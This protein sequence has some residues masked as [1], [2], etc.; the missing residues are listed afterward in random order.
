MRERISRSIF[1]WGERAE[2]PGP[3]TQS[4][5]RLSV[6][7]QSTDRSPRSTVQILGHW[8]SFSA[9]P[10][11]ILWGGRSRKKKR[12]NQDGKEENPSLPR[13]TYRQFFL[14]LFLWFTIRCPFLILQFRLQVVQ[15]STQ[16]LNTI[17]RFYFIGTWYLLEV[18]CTSNFSTP[19][20]SSSTLLLEDCLNPKA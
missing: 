2:R 19:L 11:S 1:W 3:K 6:G 7:S 17:K 8:N 16:I 9:L 4:G 13:D 5:S 14:F 15:T 12:V 10:L 20:L 18:S